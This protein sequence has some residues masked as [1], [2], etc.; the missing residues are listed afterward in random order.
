MGRT[1]ELSFEQIGS[2]A[3]AI[4]PVRT[5]LRARLIARARAHLCDLPLERIAERVNGIGDVI[6]EWLLFEACGVQNRTVLITDTIGGL[7]RTHVMV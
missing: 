2:N 4:D 7:M 5:H 3:R 6:H 1:E